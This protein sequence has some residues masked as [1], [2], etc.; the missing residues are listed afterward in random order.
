MVI[1]TSRRRSDAREGA[2]RP[3]SRRRASHP[4]AAAN[5]PADVSAPLFDTASHSSDADRKTIVETKS[6]ALEGF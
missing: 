6:Q 2:T 1:V 3:D 4:E 5:S